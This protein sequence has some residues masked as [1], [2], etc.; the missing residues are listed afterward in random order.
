M[1]SIAFLV[2][3]GQSI[4]TGLQFRAYSARINNPGGQWIRIVST[5]DW[6][7]PFTTG[8][9][10]PLPGTTVAAID[11]MPPTG[12]ANAG[13][14]SPASIVFSDQKAVYVPGSSLGTVSSRLQQTAITWTA[15]IAAPATLLS[16]VIPAG[17]WIIVQVSYIYNQ[18]GTVTLSLPITDV[19]GTIVYAGP[20]STNTNA[21]AYNFIT[22]V[23]IGAPF[24]SDGITTKLN[25]N[26]TP[27]ITNDSYSVT[28]TLVPY[29]NQ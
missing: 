23:T 22:P 14:G 26:A 8:A 10:I 15:I 18:H 5:G 16:G 20:Y 1:D 25:F 3:A 11:T 2:G 24:T 29:T 17:T 6:I 21:G 12:Q 7:P 27:R 19:T 28:V 4:A 13:T 9:I